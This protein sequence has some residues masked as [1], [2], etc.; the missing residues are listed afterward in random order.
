ML[1]GF[2]D[3]RSAVFGAAV[4]DRLE[5]VVRFRQHSLDERAVGVI[6]GEREHSRIVGEVFGDTKTRA[7]DH[8]GDCRPIENVAATLAEGERCRDAGVRPSMGSSGD[9]FDNAMCESFFAPLECELLDRRRF[10]SQS[11]ARIAIFE[12]IGG[13]VQSPSSPLRARLSFSDRVRTGLSRRY[14]PDCK[15]GVHHTHRWAA[16]KRG[17]RRGAQRRGRRSKTLKL[18]G[19]TLG[20]DGGWDRKAGIRQTL[21]RKVGCSLNH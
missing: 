17:G 6:E 16:E 8:T 12:F 19:P 2:R 15:G 10:K 4:A 5:E 9:C 7:N 20:S 13:V 11:A 14:Q 21:M 1:E 3:C 18:S